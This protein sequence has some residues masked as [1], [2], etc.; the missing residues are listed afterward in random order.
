[1][2]NY[3]DPLYWDQRYSKTGDNM[4]DWLEDYNALKNLLSQY[5]KPE[6]KILVL[7]CGNAS[8]SEDM[9]TS[10]E[11]RAAAALRRQQQQQPTIPLITFPRSV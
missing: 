5:V 3:G 2:P 7:G 1:M 4:F 10:Q 9:N 11:M 6:H 8:F